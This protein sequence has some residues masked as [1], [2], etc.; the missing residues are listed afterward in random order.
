LKVNDC[1]HLETIRSIVMIV[2]LKIIENIK[3]KLIYIAEKKIL[4]LIIRHINNLKQKKS[5]KI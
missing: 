4:Q 5:N 3:R 2:H 1:V